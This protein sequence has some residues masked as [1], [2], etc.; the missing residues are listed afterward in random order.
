MTGPRLAQDPIARPVCCVSV[1]VCCV[2]CVLGEAEIQIRVTD[3]NDNPPFF[4]ERVYT[5]RVP[6][7]T[8]IGTIVMTVTAEDLDEGQCL[9][10]SVCL[11]I[12]LSVCQYV[13]LSLY[14]NRRL[15]LRI[16]SSV[17]SSARV[18]DANRLHW[19]PS[20]YIKVIRSRS[21]SH[22]KVKVA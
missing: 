7:N 21:R 18:R 8:D 11:S 10:L 5:A 9:R 20:S 16:S 13:T 19:A 14:R 4:T 22:D 17:P 1:C 12:R 3:M 6:E 15:L 2:W